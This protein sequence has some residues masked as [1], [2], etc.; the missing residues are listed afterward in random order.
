MALITCDECGREVPDQVERCPSCGRRIADPAA[1]PRAQPARPTPSG[2]GR[3]VRIVAFAAAAAVVSGSFLTWRTTTALL[4][5]FSRN[6]IE[7][8]GIITAVAGGVML[9]AALAGLRTLFAGA[10]VV[11]AAAA[12]SNLVE[13]ATAP[14]PEL[15]GGIISARPGIGLLIVTAGATVGLAYALFGWKGRDSSASSE[16][17]PGA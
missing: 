4:G 10:C 14:T 5:T 1:A 16:H 2:S 11:G 12:V 3:R 6:G 9:I 15:E 8:D 13:A 7:G 17:S